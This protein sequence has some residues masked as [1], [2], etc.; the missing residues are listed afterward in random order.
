MLDYD[1]NRNL[2]MLVK[3]FLTDR[4]QCVKHNGSFSDYCSAFVGTPQGTNFGLILWLI[5][6]NDFNINNL[7]YV[8]YADDTTIYKPVKNFSDNVS[9]VSNK[10]W[11]MALTN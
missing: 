7:S 1:F 4:M 9:E 2:I 11:M 5:Y 10:L 8:Q 6:S 3:S